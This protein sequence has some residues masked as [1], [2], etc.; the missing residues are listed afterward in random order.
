[1]TQYLKNHQLPFI[2]VYPGN[3]F[4]NGRFTND[5]HPDIDDS[6]WKVLKWQLS[7]NPQKEEKKNENFKLNVRV[8]DSFLNSPQDKIVWLGHAAF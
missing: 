3:K 2:K 7:R 6:L 8:N 5:V 4:V 1:M